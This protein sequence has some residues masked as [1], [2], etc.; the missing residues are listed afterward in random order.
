MRPTKIIDPRE[1]PRGGNGEM[2]TSCSISDTPETVQ[3]GKSRLAGLLCRVR[4]EDDVRC[5]QWIDWPRGV[6]VEFVT[7]RLTFDPSGEDPFATFQLHL[8][9]VDQLE[10]SFDSGTA[11]GGHRDRENEGVYAG[12]GRNLDTDQITDARQMVEAGAPKTK[13]LV[14]SAVRAVCS[15]T[16]SPVRA[17]TRHHPNA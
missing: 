2:V 7:E 5:L 16:L 17:P 8:G 10:R 3:H 6:Q 1:G 12:P 9:A 14:M 4:R 11:A 15:M 13:L